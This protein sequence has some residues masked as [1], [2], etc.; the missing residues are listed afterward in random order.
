MSP[1][2]LF[3]N[4][5]RMSVKDFERELPDETLAA[6]CVECSV[7]QNRLTSIQAS[8]PMEIGSVWNERED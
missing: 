5:L 2:E 4:F 3:R 6:R 8:H 1:S 7:E